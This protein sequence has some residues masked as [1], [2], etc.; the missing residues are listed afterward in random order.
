MWAT[1]RHEVCA[2]VDDGF[3][4]GSD[5]SVG[6]RG[7]VV[8]AWV[9]RGAVVRVVGVVGFVVGFVVGLVVVLEAGR[10]V[11]GAGRVAT[12]AGCVSTG[13]GPGSGDDEAASS[14]SAVAG[15][16]VANASATSM[17]RH[18]HAT[19]VLAIVRRVPTGSGRMAAMRTTT[20]H[21]LTAFNTATA[22]TNKIHDDDVARQYGFRGGLVPGVDVYAYLT[23]VPARE[24]GRRWLENGTATVRLATPVYDGRTVT[25]SGTWAGDDDSDDSD[26]SH[27]SHDS[28]GS[29]LDLTV[30]DG[31]TTC[32]TG[33]AGRDA[34]PSDRP[35]PPAAELPADPPP[36]SPESLRPGTVLGTVTDTFDAAA[37]RAYLA[38][39]RETLS[40]YADDGIAHPGWVLRFAN[41][42]LSR[43]VVLGPWIHVS[44]D[45]AL[46]GVVEDGERVEARSVVLDEFE[47]K[48]HR[49]VT[50]DVAISADGRPVQRVTHTAIH[51]PRRLQG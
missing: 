5:C 22:S 7:V 35:E 50:L 49:F 2:A 31:A 15:A 10:V 27:D 14:A 3:G 36:A 6:A 41:Q 9:R 38:D 39:V 18:V 20:E 19:R 51:T 17:A 23:H 47:R 43:N 25:V 11:V 40:L 24:W 46:V 29:C 28:D 1:D 33:R 32:A 13:G 44:S 8:G 48:G 34:Q 16:A 12:G 30:T 37:H 26:D 45:I 42:A 4:A 21:V